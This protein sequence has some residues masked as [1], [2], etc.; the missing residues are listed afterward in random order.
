MTI[1]RHRIGGNLAAGDE[2]VCTMHTQSDLGIDTVH[3]AWESAMAT[4]LTDT[5]KPLW[6]TNVHV[7]ELVT[8]SLDASGHFNVAQ[9]RS[10]VAISGSDAGASLAQGTCIV[11][12]WTT[13]LPRRSGRG[14]MFLPALSIDHVSASGLFLAADCVTV[15]SGVEALLSAIPPSAVTI[16]WNRTAEV[17]T[18]VTGARVN[19]KPSFQRRRLNK[20]E[21]TYHS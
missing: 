9:R 15:V 12:G 17:A 14:R 1:F 21:N 11:V 20:V 6:P 18:T 19:E 5:M 16:L 8:D 13:D 4:F 7:N 3:G 2:W 10:G